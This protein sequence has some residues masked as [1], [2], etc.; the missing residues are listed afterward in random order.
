MSP[1]PSSY[2]P[3]TLLTE[4][5][6]TVPVTTDTLPNNVPKLSVKGTNW[7]IFAFCFQTAV[8]AKD[9]WSHFDGTVAKPMFTGPLTTDKT[10]VQNKQRKNKGV[11][12]H[13]LTQHIPD[14]T[15]LT[16]RKLATVKEMWKEIEWK[17]TEKGAYT[18]TDLC[19]QFLKSQMLKGGDVHQFLDD[20]WTK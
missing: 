7:V 16:L 10:E 5:S 12:K 14:S 19:T 2:R 6:S 18:Q 15:A 11:S 9:L 17:Y 13:L 4:M 20:L 1:G 8:E 3:S